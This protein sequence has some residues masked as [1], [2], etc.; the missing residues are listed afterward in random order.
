MSKGSKQRPMAVSKQTFDTNYNNI[1]RKTPETI[2]KAVKKAEVKYKPVTV[3]MVRFGA[4]WR[5]IKK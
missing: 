4:K 3:K 5:K 2:S 1:F